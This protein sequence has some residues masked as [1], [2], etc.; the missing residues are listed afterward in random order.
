VFWFLRNLIF[1]RSGR[2][3][4]QEDAIATDLPKSRV[5]ARTGKRMSASS[6]TED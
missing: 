2:C 4:F 6:L 1:G 5:V 3:A